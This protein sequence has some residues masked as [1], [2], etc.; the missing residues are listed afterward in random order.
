LEEK[1]YASVYNFTIGKEFHWEHRKTLRFSGNLILLADQLGGITV[2]NQLP[3]ETYLESVASSEATTGAADEYLK[4]QAVAA[5]ST[6]LATVSRH[7]RADPFDLCAGDH[8]QCYYGIDQVN[9]RISDVVRST[10]GLVR[11]MDHR[12]ADCRYA[13]IC[14]GKSETYP[15][16][17]GGESVPY[18]VSKSCGGS[19]GKETSS[20]KEFLDV[21]YPS[22]CNPRLHRYPTSLES[23]RSLF[24]WVQ[25]W[26]S[27]ALSERVE[28]LL[29]HK[30]GRIKELLP[31]TRGSSGRINRLLIVGSEG[32]VPVRGELLIRKLLSESHL[33]SSLFVVETE[34]KGPDRFRLHGGGWGH[35]VGMCQLGGMAMAKSGASFEKIL[36]TY[37]PGTKTE[38]LW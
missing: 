22:M 5:R 38:T 2:I 20:V 37:Y 36:D 4:A 35:G 7:H 33:P 11:V 21:N 19:K 34:G 32:K 12:P 16:V 23:S 18:L 10:R 8:C 6:V 28:T 30:V 13:K 26:E 15:E 31:V 25:E 1:S 3:I 24:R 29:G 17:W 14:G 27:P 9:S